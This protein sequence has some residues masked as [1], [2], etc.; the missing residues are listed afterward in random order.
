MSVRS[1][2]S[3]DMNSEPSSKRLCEAAK[4]RHSTVTEKMRLY[5]K[6][7]RYN[8]SW[9]KKWNWVVYDKNEE[10]MLC[11]VCMK[12]GKPPPQ[13]RGAWVTR[14]V[15]NWAKATELL[16]KHDKGEWHLAAVEAQAL[17]ELAE[18]QGDVMDQMLAVSEL[19][20]Q[21]NC[22]LLKKIIRSLYFLVRH[23]IPHTTTFEE[24]I[25]LQIEN[26]N[27]QLKMHK[28]KVPSNATYLSKI[29]TAELLESISHVLEQ[30]LL[31]QLKSSTY[32][33]IMA[34]E[35]TDIAS[36]EELSICCRWLFRGE[37]V[38][39][40]LGIVHAHEVNAEAITRYLLQF[41]NERGLSLDKLR[42][43]GFDGAS[44]MSGARTG[45]QVRLRV[46]SPSALYVHCRCYQLQLAAIHASREHNEVQRVLGTL[47]TI[48][49]TFHYSPKKAE[50]L[51]EIQALLNSP[52]IRVNKPSDTRW[53]AQE[54]CVRAIRLMFRALVET[55]E[56]NI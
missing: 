9:Q 43:L 16:A 26:G 49:K 53:L 42:G 14:P 52:Q 1:M 32:F 7:M 27:E 56:K 33:S 19:E 8:P 48:W 24:L 38:E 47:L 40:Y 15:R 55:F 36:M 39:H 11:L 41:L 44:T 28:E 21:Q 3:Q 2:L 30:T 4:D 46:H 22:K 29:T 20:R 54:R 18:Q 31:E 17:S 34:D 12:H 13:A 6:N 51:T 23:R 25:E 45:V 37:P 10:G 50:S 5:K 35:T